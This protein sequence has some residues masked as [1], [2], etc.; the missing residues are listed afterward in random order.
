MKDAPI[1][2]LPLPEP[3]PENHDN[4]DVFGCDKT[5]FY[6]EKEMEAYARAAVLA[7]RAGREE[8]AAAD[9]LRY[10]MSVQKDG[11]RID[12]ADVLIAAAPSPAEPWH[13][14]RCGGV[15]HGDI[16]SHF[17][18]ADDHPE[19]PAAP[20]QQEPVAW[21]DPLTGT[22]YGLT[23]PHASPEELLPLYTHPDADLQ[24]E[25]AATEAQVTALTDTLS[26]CSAARDQA[27]GIALG[28]ASRCG[29]A[30]AEVVKLR[31]LLQEA[32]EWLD[33]RDGYRASEE[34]KVDDVCNRID[35]ALK[36]TP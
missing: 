29:T 2:L 22:V 21:L 4:G 20:V 35:A 13:C 12:P 5:Y 30:E 23:E 31:T 16:A 15:T 3:N 14:P 25:F 6:T 10:G 9:L 26:E 7:D 34:P 19:P 8:E 27:E 18:L 28:L 24:T 36:G 1:N 33:V 11:K 17:C 32:R